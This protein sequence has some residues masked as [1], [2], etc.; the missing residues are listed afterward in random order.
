MKRALITILCVGLLS[1]ML[2]AQEARQPKTEKDKDKVTDVQK[3]KA[4]SPNEVAGLKLPADQEVDYD[5]QFITVQAECKGTVKWLVLSTEDKVKYKVGSNTT[6]IDIGIPPHEG[7]ISVFAIGVVDGKATDFARMEI[8]IK[9]PAPPDPKP[10]PKPTPTPVSKVVLPLHLSIV[11]DANKRTPA[12]RA[13][14]EDPAFRAAL[15]AKQVNFWLYTPTSKEVTDKGFAASVQK[16]G[17]PTMILQDSTGVGLSI[18]PLPATQ[19]DILNLIQ[20]FLNKQ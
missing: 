9:G 14:I 8:I 16:Y 11:E 18:G 3:P 12:I 19:A 10:D 20:P 2:Y 6:E 5:A 7:S 15:K 1:G 13:I 4:S 17:V